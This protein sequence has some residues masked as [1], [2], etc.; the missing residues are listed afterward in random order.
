MKCNAKTGHRI[1]SAAFLA[2][3]YWIRLLISTSTILFGSAPCSSSNIRMAIVG[4]SKYENFSFG[5]SGSAPSAI[6]SLTASKSYLEL[7][8]AASIGK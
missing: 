1:V 3:G 4:V 2:D 8:I 7:P 6:S 5:H